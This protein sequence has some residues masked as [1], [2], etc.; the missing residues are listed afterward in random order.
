MRAVQIVDQFQIE[1]LRLNDV[2]EPKAGPGQ[3]IVGVRAVSLNYRDL[4]VVKG[5]YSRKLP[6][7]LTICS[8]CAGEVV[9]VGPGVKRVKTGDRVAGL[10]MPGWIEGPVDEAKARTALGAQEPGVLAEKVA[11]PEAALVP[12]PEHLSMEEAATLPCAAL[13]AWHALIEKGQVRSGD[14]VLVLGSG[15]VSV[16]ALQFAKMAGA[17]V[18]ATSSSDAK[19]ERLRELGADETINYKTTP[20][21]EE[22]VRKKTGGGVDHVIEVGGAGTFNKSLRAVRMGGRVSL[23]GALAAGSDVNLTLALMKSVTVQ[24]IFVGSREMFERMNR[25]IS[26]HAM[27]PVVDHVFPLEQAAEALRYME[28]GQH[29]GKICI[30]M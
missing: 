30:N 19:L 8:D 6:L 4:L 27:H 11:F 26:L 12:I 22:A 23:I 29:F 21:W 16:F 2:A 28:S 5:L 24:G 7:P 20:D 15:G 9:E 25:A 17:R 14:T 18:I 3:A 13:T 1:S 10:F